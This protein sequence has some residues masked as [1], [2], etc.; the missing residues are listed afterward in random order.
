MMRRALIVYGDPEIAR[1]LVDGADVVDAAR[2]ELS[3][4]VEEDVRRVAMRR[5]TPDELRAMIAKARYDYG[6]LRQPGPV[7]VVVMRALALVGYGCSWLWRR[8]TGRGE[9]W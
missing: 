2:A 7:G 9:A 1:A 4:R 6:Q 5:H 8:M 3:Q